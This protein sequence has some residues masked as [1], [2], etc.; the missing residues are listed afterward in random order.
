MLRASRDGKKLFGVYEGE[1]SIIVW[2]AVTGAVEM[3]LPA[4]PD[5]LVD[6]DVHATGQLVLGGLVDGRIAFWD[7]RQGGGIPEIYPGHTARLRQVRFIGPATTVNDRVFA[8]IAEEPRLKIWAGPGN[9]LSNIDVGVVLI[10]LVGASDGNTI[11][12]GD[13]NGIIRVIPK[14]QGQW[15]PPSEVL[16]G[17]TGPVVGLARQTIPR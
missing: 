1:S 5:T 11:L 9:I 8:S 15:T 16:L 3:T 12:A 10:S 17:H 4:P 14:I 6:F 13:Q 2:S 7:L